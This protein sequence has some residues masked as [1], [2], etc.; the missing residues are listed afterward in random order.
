MVKEAVGDPPLIH[1]HREERQ[2]GDPYGVLDDDEGYDQYQEDDFGPGPFQE[3]V[4]GN[5]R[6]QEQGDAGPDA[7]A[8]PGYLDGYPGQLEHVPALQDGDPDKAEN[9]VGKLL[10][11]PLKKCDGF[12]Q[13]KGREGD[14]EQ[15]EEGGKER[16]SVDAVSVGGDEE[17][18][19]NN[20][21]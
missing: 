16:S 12:I 14:N 15:E 8:L 19:E 5:Q 3:H 11:A 9:G 13:K 4:P 18:R 21:E 20:D 10:G 17:A 1:V 2:G 7:A 6:G